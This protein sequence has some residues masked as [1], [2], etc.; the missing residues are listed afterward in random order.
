MALLGSYALLTTHQRSVYAQPYAPVGLM[1]KHTNFIIS[2]IAGIIFAVSYTSA[3]AQ[4][5]LTSPVSLKKL[6]VEQ[7]MDIEVT[8]VSKRSEKLAE[9]AS[10]IQVITQEAIHR[11][12]ATSLPEALRLAANLEVAQIDAH[13]WAISARGFNSTTA[14]KLLVLIDG[15]TVYTPLYAGV[16]WDMQDTLLEDIERIEVISGPGATLWGANA[17]NGVIN[18]TTR[19]AE[20]TQGMLVT[21]AAGNELRSDGSLRYGGKLA[22]AMHYRV[23]A[24]Y[25]DRDDT[26]LPNGNNIADAGQLAQGGFRLDGALSERDAL[27]LQGDGYGGQIAQPALPDLNISGANLLGRW[28]RTLSEQ[29]DIKVQTYWDRTHRRIPNSISEDLDTYDIDFQHRLAVGQRHDMVWGLGYR[30]IDDRIKNPVTLGFLPPHVTRQW[31]SGF[32]QDGIVLLQDKLHLTL[33]SKFEH[34]EYTGVEIQPSVRLAWRANERHTVWTAVSRAVRTPS[35]IDGE[36]VAPSNPPFTFLQ[37]NPDFASEKLL[38]YELGY[39]TQ[40]LDRLT[41]AVSTFYNDYDDIRSIE[42]INPPAP[43][44]I[45]IGNG[46]TGES[47]GAELTADCQVTD[48]W[49]LH[50]GYTELRVHLWHKP[51]STDGN[52]SSSESHDPEQFWSLRS[53]LQLPGNLQLDANFRHVSHIANQDV[54]GY[55]ELDIRLGWRARPNLELSLVGH[56]LLHAQHAEFGT[57]S[58]NLVNT[59]KEVERSVYGK[60]LWSF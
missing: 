54:P 44:P 34:N 29:S 22:D 25:S 7:L 43:F 17:V 33:G 3:Q 8:S 52:T 26:V 42:R 9:A 50:A 18:I 14:N 2:L 53:S 45:Y 36:F 60:L 4:D 5:D 32:V 51:G 23:Y 6:S 35:R 21:A 59:R 10:A 16:F 47:Y 55:G 20:D 37:G 13:Q 11:S 31:S 56:N 27:T 28:S 38:S 19:R 15:R 58:A 30:F 24:K 48:A 12:G 49:Q 57:A 46:L 41:A 40:A 39:R 1:R